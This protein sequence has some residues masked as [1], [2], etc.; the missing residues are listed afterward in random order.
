MDPLKPRIPKGFRLK[1]QGCRACEAT[2]G[3]PDSLS[4]TLKGLRQARARRFMESL[5]LLRTSTGTLNRFEKL[6][7]SAMS[8]AAN[9]PRSLKLRRSGMFVRW[10]MESLSVRG[11]CIVTMKRRDP[12]PLRSP[13]QLGR[14]RKRGQGRGG[15]WNLELGYSL[16]LG[17]WDLDLSPA[18]SLVMNRGS[19][20]CRIA[21][22]R[23]HPRFGFQICNLQFSFF[24]LQSPRTQAKCSL[25]QGTA[26]PPIYNT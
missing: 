22:C 18:A 1:A 17:A 8:I 20:L 19:R 5:L 9:V 4:T 21:P 2:L 15:R 14:G 25:R 24:N 6:R 23:E 11:A 7:R 3:L 12:L 16:D 26:T 10:F 13:S